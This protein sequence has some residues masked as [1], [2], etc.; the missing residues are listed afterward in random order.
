MDIQRLRNLTTGILHTKISDV[1]A[2]ID[3][4]IG[5]AGVMTHQIP[6]AIEALYPY[7]KSRAP[8]DRLWNGS[9]DPDHIGEIDVPAMSASEKA[10]FVERFLALP[11]LLERASK[12]YERGE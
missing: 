12:K 1:Y 6:N 2:D 3:L 4:I 8:D 9:Y 5:S 10:E 11:S 7:I